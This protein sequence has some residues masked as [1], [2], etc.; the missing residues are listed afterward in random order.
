MRK[1]D[2]GHAWAINV[3]MLKD[4]G[5]VVGVVLLANYALMGLLYYLLFG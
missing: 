3:A 4:H 2:M 1:F 5:I